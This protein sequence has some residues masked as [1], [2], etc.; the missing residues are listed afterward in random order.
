MRKS[1]LQDFLDHF[2]F[3]ITSILCKW[4]STR[5]AAMSKHSVIDQLR[6]EESAIETAYILGKLAGNSSPTTAVEL[7]RID[8]SL[9]EEQ[10]DEE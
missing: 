9:I 2:T 8:M 3:H 6:R 1:I 10:R 7:G 5:E 4:N